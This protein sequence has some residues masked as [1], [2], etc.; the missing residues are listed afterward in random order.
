VQKKSH[1]RYTRIELVRDE[2]HWET[3][4]KSLKSNALTTRPVSPKQ[5]GIFLET[6]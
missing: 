2:T 3:K 1:M 6:I 5:F 4:G